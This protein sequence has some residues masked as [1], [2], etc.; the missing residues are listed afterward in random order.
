MNRNRE[1]AVIL[2]GGSAVGDFARTF[3]R[4]WLSASPA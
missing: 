1:T 3:E 2:S 4:D